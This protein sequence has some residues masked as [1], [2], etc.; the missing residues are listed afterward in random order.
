MTDLASVIVGA[1][2]A[3]AT[4]ALKESASQAVKDA[5]SG[6]KR[7]LA[8]RLMSLPNLEEDPTDQDFRN[9]AQ[10]ELQRK[11]LD[12][13]RDLIQQ[14]REL[15]LALEQVTREQ[16]NNWGIDISQLHAAQ[17]VLIQNLQSTNHGVRIKDVEA[18]SGN[19]HIKEIKSE[20][21]SKN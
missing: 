1:L 7:L 12:S 17:N 13:D 11:N 15:T 18:S 8:G 20:T 21:P 14:V 6:L 16:L 9:A 4:V 10:K 19:I 5:Y 2:S 3:G